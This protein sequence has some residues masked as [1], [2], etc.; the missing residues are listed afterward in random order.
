MAEQDYVAVNLGIYMNDLI[1]AAKV[2]GL[3]N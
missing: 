2:E 3:L 1:K